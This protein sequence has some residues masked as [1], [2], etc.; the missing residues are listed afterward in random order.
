M[1]GASCL[2]INKLKSSKRHVHINRETIRKKWEEKKKKDVLIY[3]K[4]IVTLK[5]VGQKYWREKR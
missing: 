3:E 2:R 1:N 4:A 5:T